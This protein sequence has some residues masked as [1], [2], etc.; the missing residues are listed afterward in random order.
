[1]RIDSHQHFWRYHPAEYAWMNEQFSAIRRDFLPED[2]A[3]HL[4]AGGFDGSVAVQ[5]RESAAETDWLLGLADRHPSILA[6]VGWADLCD[7][8]VDRELARIARHPKLAGVRMVIQDRPDLNFADS[9]EHRRGIALLAAHGLTYDLLLKPPHLPAAIRLV[10]RFPAQPFVVDHLAKPEIAAR[11]FSP[12]REQLAE[13]ARRPLVSAK[14]SGLVT[15][16]DWDQWE[17]S[18]L[19]PYL[20]HALECFGAGRLMIGSDWPVCLCA[21]PYEAAMEAVLEWAQA[22]APA[23]RA[24]ILGGNAA[25]FYGLPRRRPEAAA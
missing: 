24:A 6:V 23:D 15:E 10:D 20:D 9:P 11:R 4:R 22:L 13:L 21:S 8:S 3:P 25:R 12:W 1:V 19:R 17:T 18:D 7:P 5:A 14:L 16:A 2:L